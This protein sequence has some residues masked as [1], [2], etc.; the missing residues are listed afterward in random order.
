M[1]EK[2]KDKKGRLLKDGESQ[3]PDGRYM[4]RYT[5]FRGKR[6]CT[7][8]PTPDELRAKEA[9]DFCQFMSAFSTPILTPITPNLHQLPVNLCRSM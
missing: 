7:Y 4:Y 2:R 1:S 8:A 3:R 6:H 9:P 5:D